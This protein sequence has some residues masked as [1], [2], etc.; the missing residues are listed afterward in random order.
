MA[1]SA[2]SL[3]WALVPW[4]N[5]GEL[6]GPASV[7]QPGD[8]RPASRPHRR[9]SLLGTSVGK[10]GP[11]T[12]ISARLTLRSCSAGRCRGEVRFWP[13]ASVVDC[14]C[15][16]V[17][18]AMKKVDGI[19]KPGVPAAHVRARLGCSAP[20]DVT[21]PSV[22]VHIEKGASAHGA[23]GERGGGPPHDACAGS[24][25]RERDAKHLVQTPFVNVGVALTSH[26]CCDI[27]R[28]AVEL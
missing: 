5:T 9:I 18:L 26:C 28:A 10:P 6:T 24:T 20:G 15:V 21:L 14:L 12:T 3:L 2:R 27:D 16:S 17:G 11:R 8:S 1:G 4:S 19:D 7:Y 13:R 22:R 23:G 25:G